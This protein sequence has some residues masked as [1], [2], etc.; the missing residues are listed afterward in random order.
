MSPG[1]TYEFIID[2]DLIV[3][4]LN[5]F[6]LLPNDS[7]NKIFRLVFGIDENDDIS[8]LGLFKLDNFSVREGDSDSIKELLTRR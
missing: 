8:P 3:D 5:F 6:S 4:Y 2:I 1:V 7:F